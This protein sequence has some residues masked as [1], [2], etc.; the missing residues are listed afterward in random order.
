[1]TGTTAD[2]YNDNV[3]TNA[4]DARGRLATVTQQKNTADY[5]DCGTLQTTLYATYAY[6]NRGLVT[7][8]VNMTASGGTELNEVDTTYD[9]MGRVVTQS[10]GDGNGHSLT[11]A[12]DY[13]ALGRVWQVTD[14]SGHKTVTQYDAAGRT[15]RQTD[16]DGNIVET[17][18]DAASRVVKT[19]R[20]DHEPGA[21]TLDADYLWYVTAF[22]YDAEGRTTQVTD[23]GEDV[24]YD[25]VG[26]RQARISSR[27]PTTRDAAFT[28]YVTVTD[29]LWHH[30]QTGYDGLG[31]RRCL[32]EGGVGTLGSETYAAET[33]FD[34]EPTGRLAA[35]VSGGA[36]GLVDPPHDSD[37]QTT[38]YAYDSHGQLLTTTYPDSG[39]VGNVYYPNNGARTR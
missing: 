27:R 32:Q 29:P 22:V 6:D 14:P 33:R 7:Q 18:Y 20:K 28:S 36:D 13:D 25:G 35:M 30:T 38:S 1:M 16:G 12:Y 26:E 3:T 5:G 19:I 10:V 34:Y 21:G 2:G 8:T 9:S 37:N 23:Q 17:S 4:Y 31:R 11:T 39:T 15:V 24:D